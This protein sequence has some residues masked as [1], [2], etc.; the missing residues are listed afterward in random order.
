[1]PQVKESTPSTQSQEKKVAVKKVAPSTTVKPTT[2]EV[3][4]KAPAPASASKP[5][6]TEIKKAVAP[7]PTSTEVKAPKVVAKAEAPAPSESQ[8]VSDEFSKV[9]ETLNTLSKTLK[10]LSMQVKNLQKQVG[11]E[12]KELEKAS[13]SRKGKKSQNAG[14]DKPKRAPSG[15]AKPTKLSTELCSFLGVD[16][17]TEMARTDVTKK[18]TTYVKEHN[19]Q[20]PENKKQIVPDQKLQSLLKVPSGEDLTYFNLQK[21]MKVH[22]QK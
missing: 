9:M 21:Y 18:I 6:S 2:T 17:S 3:A 19:L 13:K 1:M 16:N 4:K 5:T 15:F 7:K 14:G 20:K 12:H 10:D 8:S 11:K 22:F